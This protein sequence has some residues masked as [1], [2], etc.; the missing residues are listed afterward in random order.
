MYPMFEWDFG[1]WQDALSLQRGR[2]QERWPFDWAWVTT[3][4]GSVLTPPHALRLR[5]LAMQGY[6]PPPVS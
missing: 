1:T 6:L 3:K 5:R 2:I 4:D